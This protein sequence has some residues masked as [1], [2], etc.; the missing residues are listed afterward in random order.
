MNNSFRSILFFVTIGIPAASQALPPIV[1]TWELTYVA[2]QDIQNTMPGGVT[3][4]KMHFTTDGHLFVLKPDVISLQGATPTDY[5]F[6]GTTLKISAPG[7]QTRLMKVSFP[8]QETMVV[9]QQF[10]SQRT[11]KRLSS[12]DKKLEPESLQL[13]TDKSSYASPTTYDVKDYSGLSLADRLKG[14]WEVIAYENVPRNQAP[15][16]GFFNDIWT[17]KADTVTISRRDPPATDSVTFAFV[18]GHISSSGIG[19]GGPAGSIIDW[20]PAFD[21][22]GHL[23]LDSAYCRVVLKLISKGKES[24]PAVPLKVVLLRLK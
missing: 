23:V 11:F 7:G 21:E 5:A 3:N 15:P 19:L 16:Y 24:T 8:D 13:V 22:W 4:T 6:D 18:N 1:G 10:E 2:P 12:F 20:T 9:T 17:I 14:F